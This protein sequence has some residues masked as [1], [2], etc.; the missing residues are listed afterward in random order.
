VKSRG[1]GE[2]KELKNRWDVGRVKNQ[3]DPA[4]AE[5]KSYYFFGLCLKYVFSSLEPAKFER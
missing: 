3:F 2:G 5:R 4:M 1:R